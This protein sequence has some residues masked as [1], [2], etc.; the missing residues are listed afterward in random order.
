MAT[1]RKLRGGDNVLRCDDEELAI[2]VEGIRKMQ[3]VEPDFSKV[4]AEF[5][6][7]LERSYHQWKAAVDSL[8][9]TLEEAEEEEEATVPA[10][11]GEHIKV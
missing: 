6:G 3:E 8:T 5:R 4:Q 9:E 2:L 1:L 7:A 10:P 11:R